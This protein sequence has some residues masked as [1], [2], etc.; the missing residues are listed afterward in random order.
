MRTVLLVLLVSITALS[1][2][3]DIIQ[4]ELGKAREKSYGQDKQL[5]Q[6][7]VDSFF[8]AAN[9]QRHQGRRQF[10]ILTASDTGNGTL[11]SALPTGTNITPPGNPLRGTQGGEPTWRGSANSDGRKLADDRGLLAPGAVASEENLNDIAHSKSEDNPGWT[12]DQV[13]FQD[14]R[15]GVDSRGYFIDFDLLVKDGFLQS[16]PHSASLDNKGGTTKGSYSW[17]VKRNGEVE[18]LLFAQPTNGVVPNGGLD[19]RGYIKGVYP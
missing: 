10:P 19:N 5:I 7:A 18:S 9:N 3:G 2:C 14:D 17:Y 12:L 8:T 1:A 4:K 11:V 13:T 6:T 16:A 15:Y